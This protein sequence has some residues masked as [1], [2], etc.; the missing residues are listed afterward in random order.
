MQVKIKGYKFEGKEAATTKRELLV[1]EK[2]LP[3]RDQYV[4]LYWQNLKEASLDEPIFY[5]I[6]FDESFPKSF[7]KPQTFFITIKDEPRQGE[8]E[9]EIN[10]KIPKKK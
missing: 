10:E 6:D 9:Y 1:T 5:Y 7:G 8:P 2:E 3:K 4:T